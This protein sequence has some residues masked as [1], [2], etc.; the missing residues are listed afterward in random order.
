MAEAFAIVSALAPLV[1]PTPM[2]IKWVWKWC[3]GKNEAALAPATSGNAPATSE[4]PT[5][6]HGEAERYTKLLQELEHRDKDIV[7]QIKRLYDRAQ[8]SGLPLTNMEE[9]GY[10]RHLMQRVVGTL[11]EIREYLNGI[12]NAPMG[13]S[14]DFT[15][16]NNIVIDHQNNL[17]YLSG[18]IHQ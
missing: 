8:A 2:A 16:H 1:G 10:D 7:I 17:S 11:R 9:E 13:G 18:Q 5:L 6:Q 4:N 14:F 15:R 12:A 3:R